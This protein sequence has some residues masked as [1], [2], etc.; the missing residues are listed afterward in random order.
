[1]KFKA[2]ITLKKWG[3]EEIVANDSLR[4]ICLKILKINIFKKTSWHYHTQKES[5]FY[6]M[7][8]EVSLHTSNENN[9]NNAH[10]E[11][12][13]Q[14]DCFFVPTNKRHMITAMKDSVLLE[15]SSFDDLLDK[16]IIPH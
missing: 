13:K 2:D 15:S 6:I 9:L 12:L 16:I 7:S 4:E 10:I 3:S 11:L 14:G 8:G 5:Y 1:M